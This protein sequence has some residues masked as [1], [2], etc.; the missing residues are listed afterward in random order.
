MKLLLILFF[1]FAF[2]FRKF[3]IAHWRSIVPLVIGVIVGVAIFGLAAPSFGYGLM[4]LAGILFVIVTVQ[5]IWKDFI[6]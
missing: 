3:F 1:L 4:G 2:P 6:K 5:K